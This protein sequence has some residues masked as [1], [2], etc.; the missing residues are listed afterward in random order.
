MMRDVVIEIEL[1]EPRVCE[2]HFDFLAQPALVSNTLAVP[3]IGSSAPDRQ[4]AGR[5]HSKTAS[6]SG[7]SPRARQPRKRLIEILKIA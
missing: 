7:V 5:C 6:A 3:D 1:A 4:T 2:V